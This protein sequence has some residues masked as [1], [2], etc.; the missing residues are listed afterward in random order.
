MYD[1]LI[2]KMVEH[3]S[4]EGSILYSRA[5]DFSKI[6]P[7]SLDD[8]EMY[9]D[10]LCSDEILPEN[11][12]KKNHKLCC[13]FYL[14]RENKNYV[15]VFKESFL[16]KVDVKILEKNQAN[17]IMAFNIIEFEKAYLN[18]NQ[19]Y[20]EFI[21][22]MLKIFSN[23][24][25]NL[26][27]FMAYKY[28][29]GYLKFRLGN[30]NEANREYLEICSEIIGNEDFLMKYIKLLGD[31]LKV[32]I[33]KYT[34]RKTRADF[35]E[36][37]EFISSFYEEVKGY[38][39]TLALKLGFELFSAFLEAKKYHKCIPLLSDMKKILKKDL[40]KG[41][42]MNNG[43]HY[44]LAIACRIG[45]IGILLND[46]AS[47][48]SAIKKIKKAI[49][50]KGNDYNNKTIN[51]LYKAYR[52]T[53]AI[54]EIS[55]EQKTQLDI[56]SLSS[57][58]KRIFIPDIASNRFQNYI[59][60]ENNKESIIVDLNIINKMNEEIVRCSKNIMDSTKKILKDHKNINNT[61]LMIF[62]VSHH[63]KIFQYSKSFVT[64]KNEEKREMYK[65]KIKEY[66]NEANIIIHKF[67]ED[68]FFQT[69][70]AKNLIIDIYSSYSNILLIEGEREKIKEVINDIMDNEQ[71]NLRKSLKINE[72]TPSYGLWLK[73]KGD[74]YF[75]IKHFEA[76][77]HS[78]E[79]A[80]KILEEKNPKIPL[81]L[82]NCGT[83]YFFLQ[84]KAK[85]VEYLYKCINAFNNLDMDN[86]YFGI[87]ESRES[88]KKK[89]KIT[90]NLINA[91]TDEK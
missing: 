55:L 56:I 49:E 68:L 65:R 39:Q 43:I 59:V 35:N 20:I 78:Y 11:L 88:I 38:N 61:Y 33:S 57:E 2:S 72:K 58:F 62:L 3:F 21:Y 47:I 91:L 23:L 46:K 70:Y 17:L 53:L 4:E 86:N 30:I 5:C 73:I 9:Y 29:R 83:A 48:Q 81:I 12:I 18:L 63:D 28:Y 51:E 6:N 77:I 34:E 15:E 69:E 79:S 8:I 60:T 16:K 87:I 13:L 19:K 45:Y 76:A 89:I 25:T 75:Y 22:S 74:Y 1:S 40:L 10:L 44:Y 24:E 64:D 26:K 67:I 36:Y 50:L 80:L 71:N 54:L 27:N 84:K 7:I 41:S 32:K 42:S 52:F 14:G 90:E 82:F 66:F 31:L 37:I 85:A